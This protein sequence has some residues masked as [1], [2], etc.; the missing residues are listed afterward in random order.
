[1]LKG[2]EALVVSDITSR[3]VTFPGP[4]GMQV[5]GYI[6]EG[7]EALWNERVVILAPRYGET[8]K[9]NLELAYYLVAN[10]FKVLRID[11]TN[12]FGESD[13]AMAQFTLPGA[14]DDL[15]AAVDYLD[16]FLESDELIL[17]TSSISARC[18]LRACALDA[19]I[20]RLVSVVGVVDLDRTL[21]S[22][23]Q[24]DIF[25]EFLVGAAWETID[26]LGFEIDAANF[27][28][29]LVEAGMQDLVG[30]LQD[31]QN[32]KVP[33]LFLYAERDLWVNL[34]SVKK[35]LSACDLGSLRIVPDVGHEINEKSEAVKFAF[36]ELVEFSRKGLH[37]GESLARACKNVLIGQNKRERTRLQE[38]VSFSTSE[39][40]F[41]GDYLSKFGIMEQA[42]YYI[43]YFSTVSA[44]LGAFRPGEVILDAGCG[45]G[46][47]G[48]SILRSFMR[49][50]SVSGVGPIH[51][52]GIDL[53]STGLARSYS[54][55]V[56]ELVDLYRESICGSSMI[57]LS[58]RKLDFDAICGDADGRFPFADGSIGKVC[59]S[60][61][62][63][64]LKQPIYLLKELHRV[65]RI[66]GVAVISS[67]K[68][69]CDM[70]VVY[71][72]SVAAAY[73]EENDRD[74]KMLLSA[75]GKIKVKRD[76][77]V[78]NFFTGKELTELA[79]AAGFSDIKVCRSFGN[80]A[81][82]IRVVR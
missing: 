63:S 23:Y 2:K 4:S 82:V 37:G 8:K 27:H 62:I 34:N 78:Y 30:T 74:A 33:V 59:S 22:I 18:G 13:G 26:I 77:G 10:G 61:V 49:T 48:V 70:T 32:I 39:G 46:F 79:I 11:Q 3:R 67:M 72:D 71:H 44:L 25:G 56:D 31:A 43:E 66:G 1:M 54:R 21:Q 12:H 55:H 60:L 76:V 14:T 36:D 75:A 81:N 9:N 50:W 5:V 7:R 42:K 28:T 29:S 20:N 58:Y 17:V 69:G 53:T 64:Y 16:S 24:R 40:D 47:Y 52:C 65:L 45:N 19:R 73:S 15:L 57:S 6:D 35:V 80:Q 51:Y 38:I 68:P 41:W